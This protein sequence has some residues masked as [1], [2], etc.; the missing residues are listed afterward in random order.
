MPWPTARSGLGASYSLNHSVYG[1]VPGFALDHRSDVGRLDARVGAMARRGTGV[2]AIASGARRRR[3][4]TDG[5]H[6]GRP[7]FQAPHGDVQRAGA[8]AR[9]LHLRR[10][11][12]SRSVAGERLYV[13]DPLQPLSVDFTMANA[14]P[15]YSHPL[16][17][18]KLS[19]EQL[20]TVSRDPSMARQFRARMPEPA[21][22]MIFQA[23]DTAVMVAWPRSP[24]TPI[25]T[26]TCH[27]I[28]QGRRAAIR[29]TSCSPS[30]STRILETRFPRPRSLSAT[31]VWPAS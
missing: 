26:V 21:A 19:P 5:G 8:G 31:S 4:V 11:R 13:P 14:Y 10:L 7:F 27:E 30:A 9:A 3:A 29:S 16:R 28:R 20:T 6:Y 25:V 2:V 23:L 17:P 24:P 22:A 1:G 15:F 12:R 18:I